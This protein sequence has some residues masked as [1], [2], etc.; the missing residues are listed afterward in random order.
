MGGL[1]ILPDMTLEEVVPAESAMLILPGGE[2][3]ENGANKSAVEKAARFVAQGA[4]V[5]AI[6]AATLGLARM[7]LLDRRLHTSNDAAYLAAS[8]YR[9]GDYYRQVPAI[10]DRSVITAAGTAPV[11]FAYEIFKLLG[12]YDQQT[13]DAWFRLHKHGDAATHD[14]LIKAIA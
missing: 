14:D 2:G 11:E 5:A 7:G 10:T 1:R 13:L 8:C 9:G 6:C 3:W 4:P 12:L